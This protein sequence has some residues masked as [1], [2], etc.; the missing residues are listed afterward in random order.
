MC[1]VEGIWGATYTENRYVAYYGPSTEARSLIDA[2]LIF[3]R[4][5]P[6]IQGSLNGSF[7]SRLPL[8]VSGNPGGGT[9]AY[10]SEFINTE[11]EKR[12]DDAPV[13]DQAPLMGKALEAPKTA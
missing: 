11:F 2:L 9:V 12:H 7:A 6:F 4:S 8:Q 13:I 3:R 10:T 1:D 5:K